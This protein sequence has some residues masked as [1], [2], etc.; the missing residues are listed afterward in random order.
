MRVERFL[1]FGFGD[2]VGGVCGWRRVKLGREEGEWRSSTF[3]TLEKNLGWISQV[4]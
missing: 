2:E 3:H 1:V 4:I